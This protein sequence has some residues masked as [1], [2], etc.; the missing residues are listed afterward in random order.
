MGGVDG[1]QSGMVTVTSPRQ[2][3]G[4]RAGEVRHWRAV[5]ETELA[6]LSDWGNPGG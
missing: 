2:G 6:E 5:T 1:N 4:W 3:Q